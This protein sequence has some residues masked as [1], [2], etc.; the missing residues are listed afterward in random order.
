M[1]RFLGISLIMTSGF[2][3]WGGS[4]TLQEGNVASS[5]ALIIAG[6]IGIIVITSAM[7]HTRHYH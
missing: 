3:I 1:K 5:I 2:M 7:V 4:L 6:S